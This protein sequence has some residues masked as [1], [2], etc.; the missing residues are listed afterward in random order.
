MNRK[1]ECYDLGVFF[2]CLTSHVNNEGCEVLKNYNCLNECT[3]H[4]FTNGCPCYNVV[5]LPLYEMQSKGSCL[6]SKLDDLTDANSIHKV[7]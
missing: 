6:T 7:E 3:A 2:R 4:V 5:V 1:K